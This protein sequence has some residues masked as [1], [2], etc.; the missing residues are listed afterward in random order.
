[1]A[2]RAQHLVKGAVLNFSRTP[3]Q[4]SAAVRS[5]ISRGKE[6]Q[7]AVASQTTPTFSNSVAPL[8]KCENEH[9]ADSAIITFLQNVSTDKQVR[10]ASSKAEQDL[11][12]FRIESMM[13]QD[14]YRS[15]RSVFDNKTELAN[16][17]PEDRRLVE[18]LELQYRRNGL[19]L[20]EEQRKKLGEIRKRLS[21]ISIAFARNINEGDESIWLT[22]D[23]L[24]GLPDDYF[25]GR[26]T[27]IAQGAERYLVTTKYPDLGPAMQL[28]KRE[29]TRKRLLTTAESRCPEN[30]PLLQEAVKLRLEAAQLLGYSTH[31]EFVLEASMAKT[32]QA[33]L[34][35]EGDLRERLSVL[36]DR[37]IREIE[38]LKKADRA[39]AG[40]QFDG[41]FG[42]DYRYYSN[43]LKERKHNISDEEVKQYFPM[44]EVT[45]GV[46]DIYQKMLGLRFEKVESPSV[47][48]PDVD[49]Y[50][51]LEAEGG[52]FVGHFY[53]DLFPR[54]GKYNHACVNPIRSSFT[55]PDGSREYPV[56]VM[57]ANFPKP[58][59]SA[60][61]LLKH[62]D[63]LT[64]LHEFGHIFHHI[65]TETKW[66]HFQLES[67]QMDFVEAPSQLLEN[68]GWE[69]SVLRQF[70][71]HHRTGEPIPA[72]L[73]N[74]LVAA[75]NEGAGLFNLRQV[76]FGLFDMA[77]H[78]TTESNVDVKA[79]YN[80]L[81]EDITRFS[82]G[83]GLGAC[84]AA[85][86]G[87]MVGGYDAGYYGYLWAKVF[88]SDMYASRFLRDGVANPDTGRDYRREILLPGGSRDGA[89]GLEAF[90]GRSPSNAAFM[91]SIGLDQ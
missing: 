88:S 24:E 29:D 45:R 53:L 19:A 44:K 36:A 89:A 1:M 76:F 56:A 28:A 43:L 22:R 87:H 34:E 64:L 13:R 42:W 41:L 51:V 72:E 58:T 9:G 91:K 39:S 77:I 40:Q 35:F 52:Q 73:V 27:D 23:E 50:E 25:E 54:E 12:A 66:S 6:V 32:P 63:V 37:E 14:V 10:D 26:K 3:A 21:E 31:A 74:R 86:F 61:A 69:P 85:T 82:N 90:L 4:I 75:Q 81:R 55:R 83:G 57:L 8:A 17:D 18:K 46:L 5:I 70:A 59:P 65:C 71:V 30:I 20:G 11:G 68:W 49:M 38:D 15:V 62:D 2:S 78:N 84:G 33:V 16:L 48:H 67:V 47:W 60:P 79:T 7:N 80:R